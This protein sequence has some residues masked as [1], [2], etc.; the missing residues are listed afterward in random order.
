MADKSKVNIIILSFQIDYLS[1]KI[2]IEWFF[3]PR[4]KWSWFMH[5]KIFKYKN[6]RLW[7]SKKHFFLLQRFL[8][9]FSK[10][11][12]KRICSLLIILSETGYAVKEKPLFWRILNGL[13]WDRAYGI[14]SFDPKS[15]KRVTTGI[16]SWIIKELDCCLHSDQ[17]WT[18]FARLFSAASLDVGHGRN[19]IATNFPASLI[20]FENFDKSYFVNSNNLEFLS[21]KSPGKLV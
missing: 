16:T 20:L 12:F 18:K 9:T 5:S 1:S 4:D 21:S 6:E 15:F 7:K 8:S 10:M 11:E 17:H 19:I 3:N 2:K 13:N 14:S